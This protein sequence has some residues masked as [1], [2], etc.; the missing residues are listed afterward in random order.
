M[1]IDNIDIQA[2]IE[3]AQRIIREDKQ[4][5]AASKFMFE[6]LILVIS[7]LAS[8]LNLNSKNSGKPPSSDSNREKTPAKNRSGKKPGGQ[9]GHIGKTLT[10]VDDPD[11]IEPLKIDRRTLPP[12][13]YADDGYESR[14][15]FDID[16]SRVVTE[17][18][19]QILVDENANRFVASFPE[20]VTKAVQYGSGL[21]AH[22]V[23]MSQYQLIPYNRVQDHFTD[24]MN[25]PVSE[26]SIYN[27]NKEAFDLLAEFENRA[28]QELADAQVAHADET[29]INTNGKRIWLHSLSNPQW[30]LFYPHQTRGKEAMDTMGVSPA[31]KGTLCHDHWKAY[32]QYG[33]THSLCNAHHLRELTFAWE[34]DANNGQ[35]R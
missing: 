17:Y 3:K 35:K 21:K 4:L 27:F 10:K 16:I 32:Y 13:R 20:G 30:T 29:G 33:C 12:G 7:L 18:R 2:T 22:A 25:I 28:K 6:I 24:Q 26:G 11:F 31:L 8:R 9:K 15:V 1:K 34:Q 5:S 19:A 14:Q 23:Y